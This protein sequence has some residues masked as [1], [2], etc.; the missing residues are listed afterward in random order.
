VRELSGSS[1][2]TVLSTKKVTPLKLVPVIVDLL[3]VA[4]MLAD[5]DGF[6]NFLKLGEHGRGEGR[7][8][9]VIRAAQGLVLAT[10]KVGAHAVTV[11]RGNFRYLCRVA[12]AVRREN[13]TL[14]T[15]ESDF[16]RVASEACEHPFGEID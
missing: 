1:L 14:P 3:N 11:N 8:H 4:S 2:L 12:F 6:R 10:P 15:K 5:F 13:R 7:L 9:A 16:L